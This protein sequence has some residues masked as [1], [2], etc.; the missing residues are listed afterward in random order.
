VNDLSD[1]RPEDDSRGWAW[2]TVAAGVIVVP[3]LGLILTSCLSARKTARTF[4]V[5]VQEQRLD[6]ARAQLAPALQQRLDE[7]S[8]S[9]LS[10]LWTA[11]RVEWG[12]TAQ[13][14]LTRD[15]VPF[16]CFDGEASGQAFW[17]VLERHGVWQIV[18]A[19]L[20]EPEICH[21]E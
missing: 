6:D 8:D 20:S 14:G 16:G 13:F 12:G 7:G 3:I 9:A 11:E 17:L 2:F 18:E 1:E 4:V 15:D 10:L 5:A 19:H 21:G